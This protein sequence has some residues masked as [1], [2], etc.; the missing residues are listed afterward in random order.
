MK[1]HPFKDLCDEIY[2]ICNN[3]DF[4]SNLNEQIWANGGYF[5]FSSED[6]EKL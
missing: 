1:N 3:S 2:T 6:E 5:E 4:Y